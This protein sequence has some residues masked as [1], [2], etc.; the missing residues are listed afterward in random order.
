MEYKGRHRVI[1][2]LRWTA[3]YWSW[4]GFNADKWDA[5]GERAGTL[6]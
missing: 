3:D 6:G 1:P 5:D 2:K 4:S